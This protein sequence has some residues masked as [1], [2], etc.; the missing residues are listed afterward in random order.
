VDDEPTGTDGDRGDG[1][2]AHG[3]V[4]SNLPASRPGTRSPR[5]DRAQAAKAQTTQKPAAQPKKKAPAKSK[6]KEP[7]QPKATA[8][9]KQ[10]RLEPPSAREPETPQQRSGAG[11]EDFAWAG[12]AAAAE[13]ATLGVRLAT[14]AF[15]AL[16]QNDDR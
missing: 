14:K 16:R 1:S 15:D 10:P 11:L 5:R 8:K 6:Q 13:A 12:V 4:F 9:P 7:A 2:A 3:S